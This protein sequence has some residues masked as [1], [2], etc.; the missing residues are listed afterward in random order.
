MLLQFFNQCLFVEIADSLW[1]K[2]AIFAKWLLSH[3]MSIFSNIFNKCLCVEI[4]DRLWHKRAIYA[5]WLL[6]HP[7]LFLVSLLPG[8]D[9]CVLCWAIFAGSNRAL[10]AIGWIENDRH[11]AA[12]NAKCAALRVKHGASQPARG[13]GGL[14]GLKTMDVIA[15]RLRRTAGGLS[16][17]VA[18][19]HENTFI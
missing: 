4:A 13:P 17:L 7:P 6:S 14:G 12:V 10:G 18:S 3:S 5:K 2:R 1:Q 19:W 9:R 16:S 15:A 8:A 11:R